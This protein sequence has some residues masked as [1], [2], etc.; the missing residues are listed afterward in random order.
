LCRIAAGQRN[1]VL[2]GQR[3]KS[4]QESLRPRGQQ[5]SRKGERQENR[6]RLCAHGGQIAEA[7]R[8][9]AMAH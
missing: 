5:P 2:V 8:Q 6:Q 4:I 3:E 7:T 9:A 1:A